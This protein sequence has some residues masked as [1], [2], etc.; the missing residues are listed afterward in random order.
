MFVKRVLIPYLAGF[1]FIAFILP[2]DYFIRIAYQ[3]YH[4]QTLWMMN[5]PFYLATLP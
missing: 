3:Y 1:S 5:R 2:E 4:L